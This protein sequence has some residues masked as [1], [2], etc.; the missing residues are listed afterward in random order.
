MK[1]NCLRVHKIEKSTETRLELVDVAKIGSG[2]VLIKV[3]YSSLNYKDALAVTGQSPIVRKFPLVAGIDLAGEVVESKDPSFKPGDKVL[4]NGSGLGEEHDGGF[5]E[6]AR[7]PAALTIHLPET[8]STKDAMTLGTAGFTA[9]LALYRM[10]VNGQNPALGPIVVTGASGG[11]GSF[12]VNILA[13]NGYQVI[14]VSGREEQ[15]QR[16]FDLGAAEVLTAAQLELSNSPLQG[17]KYGGAI[18]NVGGE[19]LAQL[20]AS[21]NLWGNVTSIG[22][23]AGSDLNTAVFPFILRGVSLLGVSS[24]N[25]PMELRRALWQRLGDDL[26]PSKLAEIISNEISLSEVV[27]TARQLLGRNCYG[28]TVVKLG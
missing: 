3:E 12:A 27:P 18:D 24:A 9:A 11:V 7:L 13:Q 16:L 14:A 4:A 10:E 21:T 19:L 20:I 25:C 6:Y 23:A 26:K 17:I 5:S 2:E 15:H 8:L 22:L 28:R 1:T